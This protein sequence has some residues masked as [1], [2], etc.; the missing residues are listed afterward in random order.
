MQTDYAALPVTINP[1]GSSPVRALWASPQFR[2]S[3]HRARERH[4]NQADLLI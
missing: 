4:L 2:E 1:S 3:R